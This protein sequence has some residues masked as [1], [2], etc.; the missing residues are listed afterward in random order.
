ME[1]IEQLLDFLA[2][3]R[4][5]V[6]TSHRNPDGDAIGS[7]LGL[8]HF[9]NKFGHT[10]RIIFPSEFPDNFGWMP[11]SDNIIIY[12]NDP[13]VAKETV[14]RADIIYCL[15]FNALDRIDKLGENVADQNVPKV[16]IDHHLDPEPFAEYELSDISYSST[17]ELVYTYIELSKGMKELDID[18]ASCLYTG[19]ITDT[20]SFKYSTSPRL[21]RVV[22][23]LLETGVDDYDIQD[24]VNNSYNEKQIRLLGHCLSHRMEIIPEYS[25]GIIVLTK[26]DYEHFDIKRGDT[27]GIVNYLLMMRN[28]KIAA[29]ITE[30]PTIVKISL[31]SK[32]DFSVQE[33]A[34]KYFNGGGH[35]NA[36]GGYAFKS[37][38]WMVRQF[39]KVLPE[40]AEALSPYN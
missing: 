14:E 28:I 35:K 19:I 30:Q 33:I 39:K 24:K 6:I 13:D 23:H 18:I 34:S 9:L 8:Y 2:V 5:I 10:V 4:Y 26:G 40:Y 17:S 3:P 11:H 20:G 38:G 36:S 7:S 22:S 16:L 37:L 32:G 25:A 1:N 21:F 15:D 31:R 29:F 12:D 27:E